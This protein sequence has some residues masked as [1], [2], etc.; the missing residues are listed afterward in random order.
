MDNETRVRTTKLYAEDR[1][2][3]ARLSLRLVARLAHP[4][5]NIFGHLENISSSG[6]SFVTSTLD[7]VVP[8]GAEVVLILTSPPNAISE[9]VHCTA[10][11]VRAEDFVDEVSDLVTYAIAF[12]EAL[13]LD[14]LTGVE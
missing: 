11:I 12:D 3:D 14:V 5:G 2:V 7:P 9:E 13:D 8:D 10:R 1:R 4:L 6:A